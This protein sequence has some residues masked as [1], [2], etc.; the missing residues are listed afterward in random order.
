MLKQI[1]EGEYVQAIMTRRMLE[2]GFTNVHDEWIA[3]KGWTAEDQTKLFKDALIEASAVPSDV[4]EQKPARTATEIYQRQSAFEMAYGKSEDET[5]VVYFVSSSNYEVVAALALWIIQGKIP[6]LYKSPGD[7][8]ASW[9]GHPAPCRASYKPW[10]VTVS[11]SRST[12]LPAISGR[13][14]LSGGEDTCSV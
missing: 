2:L 13:L 12:G 6:D 9:R 3:P 11:V 1:R 7:A 4:L 5:H 10:A 14:D 8:L